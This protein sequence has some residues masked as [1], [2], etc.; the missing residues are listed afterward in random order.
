MNNSQSLGFILGP[1]IGGTVAHIRPQLPTLIATCLSL[2][3]LIRYLFSV[4]LVS[5]H[6][7]SLS[8]SLIF[9]ILCC[10]VYFFLPESLP[11]EKR[12][13]S[14]QSDFIPNLSSLYRC[15]KQ[16]RLRMFFSHK[17]YS[18]DASKIN[19]FLSLSLLGNILW[20]RFLYLTEFT[21]FE[22]TFGF[23]NLQILGLNARSKTNSFFDLDANLFYPNIWPCSKI[24][25][26][27]YW[28]CFSH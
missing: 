2:L 15:I 17:Q 16:N 7:L 13:K 20:I 18:L 10:S 19:D 6:I 8:L 22:T 24:S 28:L 27:I 3:N 9:I 11:P 1:A 5:F 12:L 25:T 26:R 14:S 21:L 23:Y 4:L